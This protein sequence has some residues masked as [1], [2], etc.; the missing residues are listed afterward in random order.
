MCSMVR[1]A[2]E[3][4]VGIH[5]YLQQEAMRLPAAAQHS[6][7]AAFAAACFPWHGVAPPMHI[8]VDMSH[9]DLLPA[10]THRLHLY[11]LWAVDCYT[12][13]PASVHQW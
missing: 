9:G 3:I 10:A 13:L 2:F 5:S 6:F 4:L 1:S 8:Q 12:S 11:M 7:S